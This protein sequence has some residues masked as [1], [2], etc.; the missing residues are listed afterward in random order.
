M[1]F[2]LGQEADNHVAHGFVVRDQGLEGGSRGNI[3]GHR[4]ARYSFCTD[5]IYDG[6]KKSVLTAE[7]ADYG[8]SCGPRGSGHLIQGNLVNPAAQKK[9]VKRRHNSLAKVLGS[10]GAGSLTVGTLND[11]HLKILKVIQITN[12]NIKYLGSS[13]NNEGFRVDAHGGRAIYNWIDF[14]L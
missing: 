13:T 14:F 2:L 12:S 8:L 4:S 7:Q 10:G 3:R 9:V 11:G 6:L 1:P 5:E